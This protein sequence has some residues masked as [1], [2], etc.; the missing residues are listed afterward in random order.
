MARSASAVPRYPPSRAC[1]DPGRV[2]VYSAQVWMA[3]A[4]LP[5]PSFGLS[6]PSMSLTVPDDPDLPLVRLAQS[7]DLDAFDQLILRHQSTMTALLHRFA[8]TR[9]DLEDLVQETFVKAWQGLPAWQ[10]LRPFLHWLKR[11]AVRC[12][13]EFCRRQQR[14]PLARSVPPTSDGRNALDDLPSGTFG[15]RRSARCPGRGPVCPLAPAAGGPRPAHPATPGADAAGRD[16]PALRLEP[17]QRQSESL[18]RPPTTQ[19]PAPTPRL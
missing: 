8:P 15:L 6:L 3:R 16:R 4:A 13:L 2:F 12:G 14:S 1:L 19:N 7:G 17:H 10:P 18:P 9:A 5:A 11:I